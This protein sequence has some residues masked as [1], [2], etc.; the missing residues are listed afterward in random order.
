MIFPSPVIHSFE[1]SYIQLMQGHS[2]F[3]SRVMR[4]RL[5]YVST[6][7]CNMSPTAGAKDTGTRYRPSRLIP[8][9]PRSLMHPM[10]TG[11]VSTLEAFTNSNAL[12]LLGVKANHFHSFTR[13]SRVDYSA[14]ATH[15]CQPVDMR[16]AITA[17]QTTTLLLSQAAVVY[18]DLVCKMLCTMFSSPPAHPQASLARQRYRHSAHTGPDERLPA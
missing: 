16:A 9:H 5:S 8:N 4:I 12:S 13:F 15:P 7:G 3:S 18:C 11:K 6:S 14:G 17:R 1:I 10:S 2:F